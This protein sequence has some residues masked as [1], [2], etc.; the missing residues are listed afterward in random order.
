MSVFAP[1]KRTLTHQFPVLVLRSDFAY[2]L[3]LRAFLYLL[4][5]GLKL[6][7]LWLLNIVFSDFFSCRVYI[8]SRVSHQLWQTIRYH[9]C[10]TISSVPQNRSQFRRS[11]LNSMKISSQRASFRYMR[12]ENSRRMPGLKHK[13]DGEAIRNPIIVCCPL[14]SLIMT[15]KLVVFLSNVSDT[16]FAQSFVMS[17]YSWLICGKRFF[18]I[19]MLLPFWMSENC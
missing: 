11:P 19:F 8:N 7:G 12:T 3:L 5:V 14:F 2:D 6:I 17:K 18:N 15:Q 16:D 9:F 10:G 13:V 1:F 4:Q